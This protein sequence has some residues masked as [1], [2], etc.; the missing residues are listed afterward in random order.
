MKKSLLAILI[1]MVVIVTRRRFCLTPPP[2]G[3]HDN[4]DVKTDE[5]AVAIE[6]LGMSTGEADMNIVRDQLIKNGFD[7][8][9]RRD[10]YP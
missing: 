7:V 6:L 10:C 5:S 1:T 9:H 4:K 3:G 8:K 2:A